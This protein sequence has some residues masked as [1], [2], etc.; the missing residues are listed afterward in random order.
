MM[1]TQQH[2][3]QTAAQRP[4]QAAFSFTHEPPATEI[5]HISGELDLSSIKAHETEIAAVLARRPTR[6]IVD[7]SG[8]RFGD[9]SAIAVWVRWA[10]AAQEFELR[11]ASS[12]LRQVL[13][14]MNL[15]DTLGLTVIS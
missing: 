1:S 10:A 5:V 9:S 13:T 12:L 15:A 7:V 11:G 4:A 3:W 8:L 2:S 6:L 14:R